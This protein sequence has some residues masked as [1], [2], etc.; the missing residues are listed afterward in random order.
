MNFLWKYA[1]FLIG[2][3][4]GASPVASTTLGTY[5]SADDVS[6]TNHAG[7]GVDTFGKYF[8][9]VR[10]LL[11]FKRESYIGLYS[12]FIIMSILLL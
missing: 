4:S 8:S 10:A 11:I 1:N 12:V 5:D 2:Y 7:G 3:L 9:V 6:V